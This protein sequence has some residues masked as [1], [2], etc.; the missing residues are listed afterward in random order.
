V[1]ISA[2]P[3]IKG[4]PSRWR[5]R[6]KGSIWEKR[7]LA[8]KAQ[9]E[10]DGDKGGETKIAKKNQG[11]GGG[12]EVTGGSTK[13]GKALYGEEINKNSLGQDGELGHQDC[14]DSYGGGRGG[15]SRIVT[16]DGVRKVDSGGG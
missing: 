7:W 10:I 16:K 6:S 14:D 1:D 5:Q 15:K 2:L 11:T 8:L 3:S 4:A 9:R 12:E 13:E